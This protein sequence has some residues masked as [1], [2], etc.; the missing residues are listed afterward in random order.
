MSCKPIRPFRLFKVL[1]AG[2]LYLC[3]SS[4]W[5]F[6]AARHLISSASDTDVITGFLGTAIWLIS[7]ACLYLYVFTSKPSQSIRTTEEKQ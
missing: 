1:M 5:L 4:Y 2:L 7:S 3:V 6:Y